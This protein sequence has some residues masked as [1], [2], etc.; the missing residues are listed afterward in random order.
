M[1]GVSTSDAARTLQSKS[2]ISRMI[3]KMREVDPAKFNQAL[4]E[5]YA[6]EDAINKMWELEGYL[7]SNEIYG[8]GYAV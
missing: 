3:N 5:K 2:V 7:L 4:G 1:Y 6:Y 8:D